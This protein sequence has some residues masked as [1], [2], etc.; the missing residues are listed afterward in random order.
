MLAEIELPEISEKRKRIKKPPQKDFI[1]GPGND[2]FP[3]HFDTI[4]SK[5]KS[6][7]EFPVDKHY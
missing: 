6:K 5:N 3:M 4:I 2:K 1:D 7:G